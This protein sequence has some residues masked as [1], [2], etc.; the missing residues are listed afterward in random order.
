MITAFD[1]VDIVN[2][3]VPEPLIVAGENDPA[4]IPA[5]HAF[6]VPTESVTGPVKPVLGVTRAV[7][8][9]IPP[10]VTSIAA[11]V[12]VMSKSGVLGS[13]VIV[14]VGGCGSELP[15][16]SIAVRD[17]SYI[18]GVANVTLPGFC[19]VDVAGKPPGNTQEYFDAV[20]AVPNVTVEPA[21]IVTLPEGELIAAVGGTVS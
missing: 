14:R 9:A 17:T 10:G 11:G 5:G 18:P 7:K 19:A 20:L 3:A 2:V 16:A 6:S 8:V 4:V 1:A 15:T 21:V 12:T 13:T